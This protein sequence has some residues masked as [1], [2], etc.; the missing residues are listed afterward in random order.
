MQTHLDE[1]DICRK[2]PSLACNAPT[3]KFFI[4]NSNANSTESLLAW[5]SLLLQFYRLQ[6]WQS[7]TLLCR[8]DRHGIRKRVDRMQI[9]KRDEYLVI[10]GKDRAP[11]VPI[12]S[13]SHAITFL[14]GIKNDVLHASHC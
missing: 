3:P 10:L 11:A 5:D 6:F 9:H 8:D 4:S 7:L 13:T 14:N 2:R 1:N 12:S